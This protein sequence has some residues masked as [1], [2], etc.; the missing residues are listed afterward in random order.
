MLKEELQM[1]DSEIAKMMNESVQCSNI[2]MEYDDKNYKEEQIQ[3]LGE[4]IKNK[5]EKI[6]ELEKILK[7][8]Q[9]TNKKRK[10]SEREEKA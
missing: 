2:E 1:K 9:S 7:M 10:R 5:D 3:A 6:G 4:E 8:R